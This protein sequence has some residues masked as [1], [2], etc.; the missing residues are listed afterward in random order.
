LGVANKFYQ[1]GQLVKME[2]TNNEDQLYLS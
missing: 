2:S 1:V